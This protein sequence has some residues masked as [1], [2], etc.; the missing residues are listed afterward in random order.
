MKKKTLRPEELDRRTDSG[1]SLDLWLGRKVSL[2]FGSTG[3]LVRHKTRKYAVR[4]R[5]VCH[6]GCGRGR[7][8]YAVSG[9]HSGA[10]CYIYNLKGKYLGNMRDDVYNCGRH[11]S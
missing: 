2:H 11:R 10:W 8:V 5:V 7:T 1:K 4:A 9:L 3:V 6:R